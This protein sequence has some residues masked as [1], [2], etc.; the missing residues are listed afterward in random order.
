MNELERFFLGD[1]SVAWNF[2]NTHFVDNLK[3]NCIDMD[4]IER[5]VYEE[6]P[7]YYEHSRDN[8]YVVY[9]EA[10]SSKDYDELKLIIAC[11]RNIIDAVTIM[12]NTSIGTYKNQNKYQTESNKKTKKQT[13]KA[14]AKRKRFN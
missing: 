14:Y 10:P 2:K 5:I 9:Y 11:N 3:V 7:L 6:D 1:T 13:A 4:Y 12:P 8:R